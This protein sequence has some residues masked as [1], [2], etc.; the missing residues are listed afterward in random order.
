M[1]QLAGDPRLAEE[2]LSGRRVGRVTLGQ[3]LDGDIA[4]EGGVAGAVD[5]THAA[6]ADFVEQLEAGR[7]GRGSPGYGQLRLDVSC[8]FFRHDRPGSL[9]MHS[10]AAMCFEDSIRDDRQVPRITPFALAFRQPADVA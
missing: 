7:V 4:I 5:D 1:L 3:Q 8:R 9:T 2:A 10:A 6:A